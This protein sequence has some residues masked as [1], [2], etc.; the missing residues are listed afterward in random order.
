MKRP[1][2]TL[3]RLKPLELHQAKAA[4]RK[5]SV[6]VGRVAGKAIVLSTAGRLMMAPKSVVMGS[7]LPAAVQL[8]PQRA[9]AVIQEALQVEEVVEE[10]ETRRSLWSRSSPKLR[11]VIGRPRLRSRRHHSS[12]SPRRRSSS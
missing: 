10:E 1:A 8:Q 7:Q 9:V 2:V 12:S 5:V 11:C 6:A 3:D 4:A